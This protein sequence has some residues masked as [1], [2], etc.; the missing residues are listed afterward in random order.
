ML[1]SLFHTKEKDAYSA[2]ILNDFGKWEGVEIVHLESGIV[3]TCTA[4][5]SFTLNYSD[6]VT[7]LKEAVQQHLKR[8]QEVH[9]VLEDN[10]EVIRQY[11]A[12]QEADKDQVEE[13]VEDLRTLPLHFVTQFYIFEMNGGYG[14]GTAMWEP[15]PRPPEL[16]QYFHRWLGDPIEVNLTE[17]DLRNG[18]SFSPHSGTVQ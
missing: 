7:T 2:N 12:Q 6:A 15:G 17:E 1:I 9:K 13:E 14:I 4:H 10:F 16:P 8:R 18:G 11:I 3:V 5:R